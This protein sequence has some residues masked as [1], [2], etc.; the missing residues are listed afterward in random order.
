MYTACPL[1]KITLRS[2]LGVTGHLYW[3]SFPIWPQRID[4][5]LLFSMAVSSIDI[6]G[7]FVAEPSLLGLPSQGFGYFEML[8]PEL[9]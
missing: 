5:S 6:L 3:F 2:D 9:Y 7:L 4:I 1:L 8:R